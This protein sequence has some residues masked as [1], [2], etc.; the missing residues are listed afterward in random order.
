MRRSSSTT[1]GW[2]SL[3][4]LAGCGSEEPGR[5]D[6]SGVLSSDASTGGPAPA[7]ESSTGSDPDPDPDST[8][9]TPSPDLGGPPPPPPPPPD[10]PMP[11]EPCELGACWSTLTFSSYCG[12]TAITENF[13]SGAYNVHQFALRVRAGIPAELTVLRTNGDLDPAFV[14]HDDAG[15]TVY[16]GELGIVREDLVVEAIDT[17]DGSDTA[18]VRIMPEADLALTVFLTGWSVVDGG[19]APPIP[20]DVT[21]ELEVFQE[22]PPDTGTLPPPNFDPGAI[23]GGYHLLPESEPPGLYERKPDDCSR[24]NERL[25]DAIYTAAWRLHELRPELTPIAVR[26]LNEGT[27]S[28]V[29]HATHDDGTHVD[30]VVSCATDVSCAD[31]IP[32]MDFARLFVDT[33]EACGILFNDERVQDA[34]NPYFAANHGYAPWNGGFMRTVSGHTQHFHVR[35]KKPDGT[36]N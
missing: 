20:T 11:L 27:C 35:V 33:G 17:G 7:D 34:I 5:A 25:I 13:S 15:E 9:T 29:D 28:T 36:C 12:S 6:D 24:G 14:I 3:Y 1:L 8:G 18:V 31:F 10:P 23:V 19:F 32:A 16:D 2:V 21:Y 30:L 4:V 26:D 22:C